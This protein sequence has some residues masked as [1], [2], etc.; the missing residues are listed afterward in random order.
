MLIDV[1][2]VGNHAVKLI[3]LADLNQARPL[4]AAELALPAAQRPTLD[5]RRPIRGFRSIS[6][7]L[8]AA[9]SNYHALQFKFERRF[10][11]RPDD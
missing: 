1:A 4:T 2:Y 11:K 9:F 6:A 10:S 3:M 7:V 8:P 5:Q